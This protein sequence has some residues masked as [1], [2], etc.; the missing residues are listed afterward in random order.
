MR[1]Q[2]RRS[3]PISFRVS[4]SRPTTSARLDP[5]CH[6]RVDLPAS[7][8]SPQRGSSLGDPLEQVREELEVRAACRAGAGCTPRNV[9]ISRWVRRGSTTIASTRGRSRSRPSTPGADAVIR[10]VSSRQTRGLVPFE[11]LRIEVATPCEFRAHVRPDAGG[12]SRGRLRGRAA[13][14]TVPSR[15]RRP[16]GLNRRRLTLTRRGSTRV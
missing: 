15:P 5:A 12:R 2:G 10:M 4:T 16:R 14:V 9:P 7:P 1:R 3:R 8:R 6:R 13:A 11:H